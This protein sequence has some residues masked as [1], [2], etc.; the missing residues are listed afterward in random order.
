MS[1]NLAFFL[2]IFFCQILNSQQVKL[3]F[4]KEFSKGD[5]NKKGN[6]I[7][8]LFLIFYLKELFFS[9]I[10]RVRVKQ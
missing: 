9:C 5:D 6:E 4:V 1:K 10:R 8:L 7:N 3:K 2:F